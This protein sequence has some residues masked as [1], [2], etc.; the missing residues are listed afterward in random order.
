MFI[1]I[2]QAF[3]IILP[4]IIAGITFIVI[5]RKRWLASLKIPLDFGLSFRSKRIFGTNKTWLGLLAMSIGTMFYAW[6][7]IIVVDGY[8]IRGL[9][10]YI[11]STKNLMSF[12]F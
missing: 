7:L 10:M 12:L 2:L 4:V 5:L 1:L 9:S 6:L 8:L 11:I 3:F